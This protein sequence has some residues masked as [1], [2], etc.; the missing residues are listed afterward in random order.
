MIFLCTPT[1][2]GSFCAPGPDEG[3]SVYTM[4]DPLAYSDQVDTYHLPTMVTS[5]P[6][7]EPLTVMEDCAWAELEPLLSVWTPSLWTTHSTWLCETWTD[8]STWCCEA[9]LNFVNDIARAIF[10]TSALIVTYLRAS[11]YLSKKPAVPKPEVGPAQVHVWKCACC[12]VKA[13]PLVDVFSAA[14][15]RK[16]PR[17]R[18]CRRCTI[19]EEHLGEMTDREIQNAELYLKLIRKTRAKTQ[20]PRSWE[21]TYDQLNWVRETI[22]ERH[23][24]VAHL[25]KEVSIPASFRTEEEVD[26]DTSRDPENSVTTTVSHDPSP[27]SSEHDIPCLASGSESDSEDEFY[28]DSDYPS[29]ALPENSWRE[30]YLQEVPAFRGVPWNSSPGNSSGIIPDFLESSSDLERSDCDSDFRA[31]WE[32]LK[33]V[34]SDCKIDLELLCGVKPPEPFPEPPEPLPKAV[35]TIKGVSIGTENKAF[36][37]SSPLGAFIDWAIDAGAT[38]SVS[39][40]RPNSDYG[41]GYDFQCNRS[42]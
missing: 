30:T 14:Q 39:P 7:E 6:V 22:Q 41:G 16:A 38:A 29:S 40:L 3:R 12:K 31:S 5:L 36:V 28:S 21:R 10:I 1:A 27:P 9:A 13:S 24:A 42:R 4:C 35:N 8:I 33:T 26:D 34:A 25:K 20:N 15:F 32:E 11:L 2:L 17:K 19:L 37:A 23:D 18:K